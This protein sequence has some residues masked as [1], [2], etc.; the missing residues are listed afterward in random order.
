MQIIAELEGSGRGAYTGAMGWLDRRRRPGPEH[1]DPQRRGRGRGPALPY[2]RRHRGRLRSAARAGRN[3]RQGA[4]HAAGAGGRVMGRIATGIVMARQ[5]NGADALG[6]GAPSEYRGATALNPK[7][8]ASFAGQAR[9]DVVSPANRGLAYG[10]GLFETMRV[11]DGELPLWPRHLARLRDGVAAA[12]DRSRPTR[13]SCE[14]RMIEMIG[15]VRCRRAQAAAHPWRRRA[16]LRAAGR[17]KTVLAVDAAPAAADGQRQPA[18]AS[19]RPRGWRSSPRWP[20]SS[21]ATGWNRCW[22]A[23]K[24][25]APVATKG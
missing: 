9:V 21:T 13:L 2:R 23:P 14:A 11:H 1:P 12:R 15:G 5:D 20:A 16:R 25:S 22:R 8:S 3:P 7:A 17:C 4:R 6:F 24:S 18:P 10:D 19:V